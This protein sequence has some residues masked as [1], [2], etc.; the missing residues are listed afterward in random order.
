MAT[1]TGTV[2]RVYDDDMYGTTVII[3]HG[4][5][6][7]TL[8]GHANKVLVTKGQ[9][10]IRGEKVALVGSTGVSNGPHLHFEVRVNGETQNPLAWLP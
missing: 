4:G 7:S 3:D 1:A 6:V 2:L 5:G 10:V 9:H 8:Y